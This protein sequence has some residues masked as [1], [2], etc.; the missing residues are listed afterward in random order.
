L[1]KR[2]IA[3]D[4]A[5]REVKIKPVVH[6]SDAKAP[7]SSSGSLPTN[8]CLIQVYMSL[9]R[10]GRENQYVCAVGTFA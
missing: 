3:D 10:E 9:W 8:L 1:I 4:R 7:S 6:K 2:Q 5:A